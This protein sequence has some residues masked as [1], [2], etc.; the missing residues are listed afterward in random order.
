MLKNFK[1]ISLILLAGATCFPA[2]IFAETMPSKQGMNISQQNG[3]VTGTVVDDLG[4]VAGASVVVKGTTNG[5]ITDMDGNFTLEGVKN[6]DII[7]ISFIG[8]TTQE[9]KYTGQS[10]L[11]IKLAEDTQKL[12]EVVVVG[13]GV[14]KKVNLTGAVGIADSEILEDRPI[15]NI[16]Q[17]LQG[18]IPNLNIDFAS[19]NP[20]AATTFN[21][22]GATSLNGGQAL[23]LVDGV[24]TSDLSLLNPQDIESV[25]VLK[26]AAS[27]SIYGARAAFGVVLITTKKG[28]KGRT[29]VTYDGYVSA[30]SAA[31]LHDLLGAKD[32]VTIANEKYE[33]WGMKGQAVY[34]PNGPDTNWNDYIFRTGFQHNHSLSASGGTDKSQYYVSLGFTEQEGIIRANDLNRLSLKA[35]L[36]QQATKWLRIG[37][38]GQMT[39]TRVNGV[40]NDENS[41]GGVGFAGT[42]MLP[43]VSVFNPDDPTGYN[44]DAE[45]RK[46]LGRGSNL[47]YIDNG[48]QNIVW[49]LDNNVNRTTNTRVLGGG[50]A[51][52]TFMDGLTLKTQA[53]LDISN[54]KDFMV[55]N[56]ESGDGYGYGG[57]LEEINTTYTNWNWQNVINFNR[58]FNDVHNLTATAVQEY[59]HQEYEYTDATVQ[60]ISDAFFTDHII[61]NTFGERFVS[62]GKTFMGLASY[63]FR[64][65]Y[66]DSKYYI[67]ASVRT[68]G[69]SSL[70]KDTRWGTFWGGSA[71]WR[72]SREKFWSESTINDWFNDLRI[73][74]SYATIG[75]SDLGNYF[76]YLG[77]YGAKKAGSNTAIAWNRMGNSQLKWE[78][79]ETFDIGLDGSF[80]NNRLTFELAYWQKNSK[81]LVLEVPT[82]PT[83]GIPYN[84]YFDNIGKI[85]NSGME[86]TVNATIIATKDWNWQTNFNFSTAKNTVKSLYGGTDIVDNYTIIREGES[87]RSLYGYDY[88]G[89]NAANGNP[90][91]SKADGS[92]VQ[93]DTFG[94]YDYA[95]YDPSNPSDVSKASS[96]DASDRKV[97]G[98]SM[99][100]WY[101]G[102]NNT[103]SYKNFDL[104]VFFRFSGGRGIRKGR[105][106]RKERSGSWYH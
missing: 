60:Q 98:S 95:E 99:P 80:F 75:N 26:D 45:N 18:A 16:A 43:N 2:S 57:L 56:P 94:S 70:P 104:N 97:L 29:Q 47:S 63:M 20:N 76:P 32:F 52:I 19:G 91:W 1:P 28:S 38:N 67:G 62:G 34:D 61:S 8:Y 55:W 74:A 84:S 21:V 93:F 30:A 14:Q 58:T 100:T 86:L 87:Y 42:R 9:I 89:V 39:R 77:T 23:L 11:Q 37:L 82:A 27:A 10:T 54:V 66:Y 96:L 4:P 102:W 50:W 12:E 5:N 88:Y 41:L 24:E 69:L 3:K 40:M 36:T 7:Q 48:I 83:A 53:G 22:R 71:A 64:A 103:V 79:T 35:D 59:T 101:G 13:Y 31:K 92:L 90:I 73:R 65:N 49:A 25:S 15:G 46:T 51:E 6:G 44:I 33:N 106:Y 78:T 72:I 105:R 81:D 68:D 17:G 85:K